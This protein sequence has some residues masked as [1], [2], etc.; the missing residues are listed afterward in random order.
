M[1]IRYSEEG[2][3]RVRTR[4]SVARSVTRYTKCNS[5]CTYLMVHVL[6]LFIERWEL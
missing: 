2:P 1:Y 4:H 3:G 5:Q 6:P